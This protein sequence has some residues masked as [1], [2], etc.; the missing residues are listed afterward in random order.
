MAS[1]RARIA[2]DLRAIHSN[3]TRLAAAMGMANTSADRYLKWLDSGELSDAQA[4]V[5]VKGLRAVGL[6]PA[7][8]QLEVQPEKKTHLPTDLV[9][10]LDLFED[11]KEQLTALVK[12]LSADDREREVLKIVAE[13]RL[14]RR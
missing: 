7:N 9:P 1:K 5:L 12:I 13:D 4:R 14:K 11:D 10:L 2:A 6:D 3:K 8:Y